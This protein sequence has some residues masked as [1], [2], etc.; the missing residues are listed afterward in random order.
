MKDGNESGPEGKK[1]NSDE[2]VRGPCE[3]YPTGELQFEEFSW[4]KKFNVKLRM[5][6]AF[7]WERVP[8]DAV[9]TMKLRGQVFLFLL[10]LH[11][12]LCRNVCTYVGCC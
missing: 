8:K 9:L 5:L 2:S 12:Y 10:L 1:V 7:P 11:L 4:W 3:D 6:I